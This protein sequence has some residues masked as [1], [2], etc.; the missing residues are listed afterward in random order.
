MTRREISVRTA[1]WARLIVAVSAV[2]VVTYIVASISLDY[3]TVPGAPSAVWWPVTGM[4]LVIVVRCPRR[5]WWVLLTVFGVLSG[6]A[7]LPLNG[8]AVTVTYA[9]VNVIE[10]FVAATIL[11]DTVNPRVPR[12]RTPQEAMRFIAA[13][14]ASVGVG[15]IVVATRSV[16][17]PRTAPW[18]EITRGYVTTHTLGLFAL[19]P[20]LL[21]GHS[22]WRAGV[23]RHIEFVLVLA[24]AVLIDWWV[25]LQPLAGGRAFPVLLPIIWAAIRLDPVRA[26]AISL[27]TCAIA[28]YGTAQGLG[29]FAAVPDL[30]RRQLVTQFLIATVSIT[31]LALVLI[32]RHRARL[33][34]QASDSEQTLRIAIQ[35]ALVGIYSV[36]LDPGHVGEI[37]DVNTA[38][39]LMLGY[40]AGELVGRQDTIFRVPSDTSE[41]AVLDT[42]LQQLASG[43]IDAFQRETRFAMKSGDEL[44]VEL[45]ATRLSPTTSAPFALIY[46]HD[47]TGRE[48]NKKMLESM[49]LHDALTGLANRAVLFPR[50]DELL[51]RARREGT[52]AGL[53]Y[54]DLNG[55][56]PVNDRHGHAAGDAVLVEVARRL[57][58]AVRPGDTVARLGGD[59]F[60][61]LAADISGDEDLAVI[62][63]RIHAAL[64]EPILLPDGATVTIS[65]SI[66]SA[67]GSPDTTADQLVRA[68]DI[69]M[70][71]VKHSGRTAP[72]DGRARGD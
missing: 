62:S 39:A 67:V 1:P 40:E 23:A 72:V 64:S 33:A 69:A 34:A 55:F 48:Q 54:L 36:R 45:S 42:R 52:R 66:G 51:H 19:A 65:S 49:A 9:V 37:L 21:P 53:L 13:I 32:T 27:L 68:A 10:V 12:L 30:G 61:V 43:A 24:A 38:M 8:L 41:A 25:F 15:A 7:S 11:R 56:K 57:E 60:A 58:A 44:W 47:L 16:I 26:T 63:N 59:E 31:T 28:A 50:L 35:E 71:R 46:V 4:V 22:W 6:V 70:Y 20:L 14:V 2:A 18:H 5:W 29:T 17:F 3:F